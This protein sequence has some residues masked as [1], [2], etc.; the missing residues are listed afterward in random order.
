VATQAH[1]L[2]VGAFAIA[3]TVIAVATAIWLGASHWLEDTSLMVTYFSESVQ[4]LE[5]GAAVKYR[6]VPAGRVERIDIAP[7]GDL[8]QVVMS[9]DTEFAESVREDETLRASLQLAGITGL[10]YVEIDR[11]S[12]EA[13]E[14]SPKLT[15]KPPYPYIPS[16]PSSFKAVTDALQDIYDKVMSVDLAGISADTRATLQ[17]ADQVLRD[18]RIF[19]ILGN[20]T[21]VSQ[22]AARVTHN[23]ENM[24]A[25]VELEPAVK[26][27]E[28]ATAQAKKLFAGLN[29]SG[30]GEQMR[31]AVAKVD[32]LAGSARELVLGLQVSLERLNRVMGNLE[33][34]SAEVRQQPSRLLF[35]PPPQSRRPAED[36]R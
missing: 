26:N 32:E 35:A 22:S 11:H 27:L 36:N 9:I 33:D 20:L 3:A 19:Q 2:R 10:R 16:T 21:E 24:T 15:F 29:E 28:E 12:G 17:A 30:T 23:L 1:K 13:L 6:G 4:G 31:E 8:I 25:R 7:D 14:E 5:P 18:E 34:L